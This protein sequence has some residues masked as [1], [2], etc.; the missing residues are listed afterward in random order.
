MMLANRKTLLKAKIE[1]MKEQNQHHRTA[2]AQ[3]RSEITA[4]QAEIARCQEILP[5]IAKQTEETRLRVAQIKEIRKSIEEK[6]KMLLDRLINHIETKFRVLVKYLAMDLIEPCKL[7]DWN[8][9]MSSQSS[10]SEESSEED[11]NE[12]I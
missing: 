2:V 12:A 3:K 10:Y 6:R 4:L 1:R 9:L 8:Q 11:H 5:L 7:E